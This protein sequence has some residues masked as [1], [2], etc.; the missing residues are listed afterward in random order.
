MQIVAQVNAA[1]AAHDITATGFAVGQML[2]RRSR[3]ALQ[4]FADAGHIIG[5]H[6]WSHPDYGTLSIDAFRGETQRTD[7]AL[8]PWMSGPRYYRFPYLREGKTD[9]AKRAAT[10]V[11]T[12]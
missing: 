11:L 4:A 9:A 3:R 7:A 12:V 2:N 8:R 10:Q 1:L 5:N 6:S